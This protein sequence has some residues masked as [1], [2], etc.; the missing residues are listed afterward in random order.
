MFGFVLAVVY[1]GKKW[2]KTSSKKQGYTL[3]TFTKEGRSDKATLHMPVVTNDA[4]IIIITGRRFQANLP[5]AW[6]TKCEYL[7]LIL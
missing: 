5:L 4:I 3:S 2:G 6:E 1:A 7:L